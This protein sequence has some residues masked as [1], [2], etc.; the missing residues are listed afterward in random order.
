MFEN[1]NSEIVGVLDYNY[2]FYSRYL[3]NERDI[4]VWLPNSSQTT[5]KKYPVLYMHDG[6]NLFNPSTSF[7]GFD[8]RVDETI[9]ELSSKKIAEEIIV[10]GINNTADRLDEYNF[11]TDKGKNYGL[12]IKNELMPF[13]E[14]NYPVLTGSNNTGI[15]GSSMGGLCSFQLFWNYPQLFGK[16]GC[17]SSSFFIDDRK[18]FEMI[19]EIDRPKTD[20][21]IYIDCGDAEK[22]LIGDTVE[23]IKKLK[24]MEIKNGFE[25]KS[26]IQKGGVHS[27]FDWANRL[28]IPLSFLFSK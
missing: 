12:F 2:D 8:W 24:K 16:A 13:I 5:D 19:K 10:V 26:H 7:S 15:M 14:E 9:T 23:M 3:K 20:F 27:E 17:L 21:K 28:H 22:Q 18:I 1:H 25:L 6:Q 11:F 4:L